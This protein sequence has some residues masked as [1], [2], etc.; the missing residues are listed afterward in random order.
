[1]S[2]VKLHIWSKRNKLFQYCR[3]QKTVTFTFRLQQQL[4]E[5]V[6]PLLFQF[7]RQQLWNPLHTQLSVFPIEIIPCTC[8]QVA[9]IFFATVCWEMQQFSS[10]VS[11]MQFWWA[12]SLAACSLPL[13][14]LSLKE[15][16][17]LHITPINN[18]HSMIHV[19]Q[20]NV[21]CS[22]KLNHHTLF[23]PH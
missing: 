1:M 13:H 19:N 7:L 15:Y 20:W 23:I 2:W 14:C 12:S 21:F 9:A 10:T 17:C 5:N 3:I 4:S 11:S 6:H 16:W 22:Q 18:F 8:S